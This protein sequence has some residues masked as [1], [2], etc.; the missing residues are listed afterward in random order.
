MCWSCGKEL[1]DL[2][3][4]ISTREICP[5]C[6]AYLHC[7]KNCTNYQPGLPNDCKVPGTDPIADRE[8][9]NLCDEFVLLGQAPQKTADPKDMLKKLFGD[10]P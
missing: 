8:A 5:S 9:R 1:D 3:K 7:C 6:H 4:R 2:P 10:A